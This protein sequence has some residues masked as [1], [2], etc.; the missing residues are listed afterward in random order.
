MDNSQNRR[1]ASPRVA[2][3]LV[4]GT[5][6]LAGCSVNHFLIHPKDPAPEIVVWSAD[7]ERDLL[8]LH[9]EGA[10]PRG[11]GPFPTVIVLPEEEVK[12][13]EMRG[14]LFD[15]AAR[16]YVAIAGSYE[17]LIEGKHRPSMFAW[18]T[19][20]DLTLIVDSVFTYPE[21]DQKRLGLL[22]FSEGAVV[23]LNI[24]AHD[25]ERIKAVVAYYPIT[26]FPYWIAG[27]RSGIFNRM[28]FA[29]AKWQL[30]DE[31]RAANDEDYL[32]MLTISSPLNASEAISAPTLFIVGEKDALLPPEESERMAKRMKAA[33][34]TAEVLVIP[35]A[36]RFF[37]YRHPEQATQS[38][39]AAVAWL[40]RYLQPKRSASR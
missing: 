8:K 21:V 15:L 12:A 20:G 27:K 3:L 5:T 32:T 23:N 13:T 34:V 19:Q 40:D 14:M 37:N 10:R 30:R 39:Q 25:P 35:D 31:S 2:A 24:A 38:W 29:L 28:L 33:G 17:R 26:D 16:G 9:I 22:G 11:K 1:A 36:K 6:L 18:K 7:F 4:L